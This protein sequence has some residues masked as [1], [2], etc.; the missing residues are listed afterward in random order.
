M[1]I[2]VGIDLVN[3]PRIKKL[4]EKWGNRF[5]ERVFSDKEIK[6]SE[7][8]QRDEQHFAGN[9]AVKEA[10]IKALGNRNIRLID[11]EVIRNVYGKPHINTY[12]QTKLMLKGMGIKGI[13]TS[14][15]HDGE[16]SV[17]IVILEN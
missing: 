14:I 16:Y 2:G 11:I 17:A 4:I 10:F 15:S 7:A 1:I 13:H 3:I 5:K 8:H 12:G 9:F 6:Y